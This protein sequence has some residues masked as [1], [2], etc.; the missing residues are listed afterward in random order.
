LI[1]WAK[2]LISVCVSTRAASTQEVSELEY[3]FL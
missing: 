3:L 1:H 2:L